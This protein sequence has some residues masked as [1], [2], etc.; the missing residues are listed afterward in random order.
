M[1]DN[2][3]L[4]KDILKEGNP[5]LKEKSIDVE[6]PISLEDAEILNSMIEYIFNSI[7]FANFMVFFV[8]C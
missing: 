4:M 6:L 7:G 2:M 1:V 8:F 3:I 5:L